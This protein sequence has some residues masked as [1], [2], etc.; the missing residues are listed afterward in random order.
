MMRKLPKA[1]QAEGLKKVV[2]DMLLPYKGVVHSI[3]SDNG[4]EFAC[5]QEI[6]KKLQADFYFANP[7]SS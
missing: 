3:T 6:A 7:Y 4:N 1:K 2:I 5:H